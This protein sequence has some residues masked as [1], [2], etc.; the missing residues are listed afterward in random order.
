[1]SAKELI[2]VDSEFKKKLKSTAASKGMSMI[3]FT[4]EIS[5]NSDP[6]ERLVRDCKNGTK[7]KF[8][9]P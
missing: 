8:D 2:W 7:K 6:I 1:M 4:K 3:D 9:F 5:I